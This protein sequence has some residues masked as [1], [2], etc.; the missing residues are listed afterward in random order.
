[1]FITAMK[2]TKKS[3][4]DG[5][6]VR[7]PETF[8][9]DRG[10]LAEL[11]REDELDPEMLPVM[12]YISMTRPGISRGPHEHREQTDLICFFGISKFRLYLW[13]NRPDSPTYKRHERIETEPGRILLVQIP[14]GVVHGYKNIG[15]VEGMIINCPNRLYAG[16]ERKEPVDEIR[17]EEASDSPFSIEDRAKK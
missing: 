13:D 17:H 2:T 11:F 14:P 6:V 4:I 7:E 8:R 1:M 16:A 15:S 3:N 9:D 12:G 10:W 5:V